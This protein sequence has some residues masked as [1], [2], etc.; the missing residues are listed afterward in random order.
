MDFKV[1]I[2][3]GDSSSANALAASLA[4]V[5]V[6]ATF[7][8]TGEDAFELLSEG[9]HDALVTNVLLDGDLGGKDLVRHVLSVLPGLPVFIWTDRP[10]VADA[11]YFAQLGV[12]AYQIKDEDDA[13]LVEYVRKSLESGGVGSVFSN[14]LPFSQY[15]SQNAATAEIFRTAVG[16]VAQAPTTVLITGE[17]GTGK[18]LLA[19]SIHAASARA[20]SP[21]VAVNCG[22]LA[23]NLIE[24]ELFGH[25]KGA[26]TGASAQR[27]GRFE[28]ANGGTFFL[29]EAGDLTPSVQAKLLRVLQEHVIER[30]GSNTEIPVDVRI[31]AATNQDLKALVKRGHFREDLYYRL[32]VIEL[33]L[34]PLRER[35][36]DI[37]GLAVYFVQKFRKRVG[38]SRQVLTHDAL[39]ALHKH[40]WP[41]NVREL[42]NV[43]ERAVVLSSGDR[44]DASDL[45]KDLFR[46]LPKLMADRK[47][48]EARES[49][50]RDFILR[51]LTRHSG[52][53]SETSSI[54][55][56]ARKNLQEKIRRYGIDVE[57]LREIARQNEGGQ[58][59]EDA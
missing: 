46:P 35:A 56:I 19:R 40:S 25:E 5:S 15:R 12:D 10:S 7:C 28:A 24:S 36:E 3:D 44:I 9:A 1:I 6:D 42:A 47:L 33:E 37:P 43:M 32:S 27:I 4:N 39:A 34:P 48:R 18:E 54:L 29:D 22:A 55:G 41:G 14:R 21:F 49:F 11:F 13:G 30:I 59:S 53:V 51:A 50:E 45:P 20:D 8:A 38:R 16:K 52:N 23:E 57:K 26:F 31:I 2:C 17:S 58:E